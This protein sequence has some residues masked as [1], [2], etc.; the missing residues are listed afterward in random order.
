ML[1]PVPGEHYRQS[2]LEKQLDY[3]FQ[4]HSD[5]PVEV[6]FQSMQVIADEGI[7]F[8]SGLSGINGKIK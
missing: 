7:S 8:T 3:T 4:N 2:V 1:S 5:Y 6:S